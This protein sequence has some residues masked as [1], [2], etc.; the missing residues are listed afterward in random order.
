MLD[1][2]DGPKASAYVSELR[3]RQLVIP[4]MVALPI[5]FFFPM[6]ELRAR[7]LVIPSMVALPLFSFSGV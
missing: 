7:Q 2:K 6:S 5:F 1:L 3:A 4:F